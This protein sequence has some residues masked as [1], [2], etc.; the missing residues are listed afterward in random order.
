MRP[1]SVGWSAPSRAD[2][3]T[4][5]PSTRPARKKHNGRSRLERDDPKRPPY[6]TQLGVRRMKKKTFQYTLEQRVSLIQDAAN[7]IA[8]E[9]EEGIEGIIDG[10]I[11]GEDKSPEILH[12]KLEQ[13]KTT[14]M[15]H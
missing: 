14:T 3:T 11:D 13:F 6:H 2:R 4:L 9:Y 1:S 5:P 7:K 15:N 8:M 10:F 12:S